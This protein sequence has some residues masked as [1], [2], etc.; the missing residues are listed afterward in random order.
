MDRSMSKCKRCGAETFNSVLA[1]NHQICQAC[2]GYFRM[3]AR[4][5]IASVCDKNSFEEHDSAMVSED[6]LRFP[7]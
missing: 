1:A 2:G 7:D 3:T 6:I 4:E 5:R